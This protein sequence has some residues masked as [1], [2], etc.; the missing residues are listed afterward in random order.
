MDYALIIPCYNEAAR[1]DIPAFRRF[2]AAH[3]EV[4]LLFVD[5][6]STDGTASRLAGFR[7]LRLGRNCG[8]GEAIR[9]GVFAA[10]RL[11]PPVQA[12]AFLD[13]DLAT[14][15]DELARLAS[16][17]AA[18]P[19]LQLVFGSR[20]PHWGSRIRRHAAR[21]VGGRIMAWMIRLALGRAVYD[22]QC[23]AKIFRRAAVARLFKQPFHSRW[24][25][26]VELL[27][28][29]RGRA[30][31]VPL[32][33]WREVPGSKVGLLAMARAPFELARIVWYARKEWHAERLARAA[34][35]T[36]TPWE[37]R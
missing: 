35:A 12:I 33:A 37:G 18:H 29:L 27:L 13:A 17:L 2:A 6:G 19:A 32:R 16:H 9:Q 8:K 10:L 1:L 11:K 36:V 3:P 25:F 28:R 24:L 7:V 15:L 4:M 30:E 34:A 31:E 20:W 22:T 5:D 21:G 14:G 26:D 23:G